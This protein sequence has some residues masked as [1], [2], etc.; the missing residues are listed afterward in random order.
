MG[1]SRA[2]VP[3]KNCKI[4]VPGDRPAAA[5]TPEIQPNSGLPCHALVQI[6]SSLINHVQAYCRYGLF[7]RPRTLVRGRS[8]HSQAGHKTE[9]GAFYNGIIARVREWDHSRHRFTGVEK[10]TG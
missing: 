5:R 8:N 2:I 10:R 6:Q 3:P 1:T 9:A 4:V 7:S